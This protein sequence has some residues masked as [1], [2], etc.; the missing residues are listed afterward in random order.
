MDKYIVNCRFLTQK[1]TGA[2]RFAINICLYLKE[3]SD[4]F[5]FVSPK[6][7]IHKEIG[8]KLEIKK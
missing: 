8:K 6:N 3:I 4:D 5:I 2:Q 7:I 1:L